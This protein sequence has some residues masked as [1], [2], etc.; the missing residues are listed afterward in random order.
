MKPHESPL[1]S[2]YIFF[3]NHHNH[4][5]DN[6]MPGFHPQSMTKAD[7]KRILF[8]SLADCAAIA[9]QYKAVWVDAHEPSDSGFLDWIDDVVKQLP[10][11]EA[12]VPRCT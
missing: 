10:F 11:E 9:A 8:K 7:H 6:A 1:S 5:F 12:Q 2:W 3:P 4:F